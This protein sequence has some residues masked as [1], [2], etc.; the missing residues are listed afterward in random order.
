MDLEI[1]AI[2]RQSQLNEA[3]KKL[4]R[5]A[6]RKRATERYH[7]LQMTVFARDGFKCRHCGGDRWLSLDHVIP[8]RAGGSNHPDN[9]QCLC[10]SCNSKKVKT[11]REKFPQ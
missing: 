5:E 4:R 8:K 9:L 10:H 11:D 7:D 2:L 6:A 3:K 1:Q